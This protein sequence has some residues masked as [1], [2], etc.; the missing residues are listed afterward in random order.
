MTNKEI[1]HVINC[2]PYITDVDYIP[3][4][5]NVYENLPEPYRTTSLNLLAKRSKYWDQL[6]AD[7]KKK[8]E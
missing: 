1:Q 5:I 4:E 2:I 8:Y 6:V 7:R 3:K